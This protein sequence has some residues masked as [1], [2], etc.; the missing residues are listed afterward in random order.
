MEAN[1]TNHLRMTLTMH[2][3]VHPVPKHVRHT[4]VPL[5][6]TSEQALDSQNTLFDILYHRFEVN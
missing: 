5:G 3:L 1:Q 2:V 6:L 4:A